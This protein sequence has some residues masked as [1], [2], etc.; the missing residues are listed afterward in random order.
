M[1]RLIMGRC[2]SANASIGIKILLSDIIFQLN[3]QNFDLIKEMLYNGFIDDDNEYFNEVFTKIINANELPN[4][5]IEFK[6]YI[7][8]AFKS[9]GSYYKERFTNSVVPTLDYGCLFDKYLLF[10]LKHILSVERWGYDRS[11]KNGTST[12]I[13]F[14]LNVDIEKYKEI[15]N[16]QIVFILDIESG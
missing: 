11:G 14:D 5:Y 3:E 4:S 1:C 12:P 9:N 6:K 16:T 8:D 7:E 2:E 13:D 10:P 15:K